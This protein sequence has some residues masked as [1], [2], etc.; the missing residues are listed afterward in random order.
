MTSIPTLLLG[1]SN[2]GPAGGTPG[3]THDTPEGVKALVD[4]WATL[5][6]TRLDTAAVYGSTNEWGPGGSE[7]FLHSVGATD[8]R[9]VIDTKV[10]TPL[11]SGYK[12]LLAHP[13]R[14]AEFGIRTWGAC[15]RQGPGLTREL[16]RESR[17]DEGARFALGLVNAPL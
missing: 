12:G 10:R 8:G 9:F 2:I 15:S 3:Y 4:A 16:P 11:P 13:L 7:R 1:T 6:G 14:I 5:G 17:G